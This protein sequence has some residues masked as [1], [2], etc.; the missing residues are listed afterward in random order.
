MHRPT[1]KSAVK[2]FKIAPTNL[3]T[4]IFYQ[5]PAIGHEQLG[6]NRLQLKKEQPTDER[7]NRRTEE[8]P[9][10]KTVPTNEQI[11]APKAK[12]TSTKEIGRMY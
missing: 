4:A 3:I 7:T 6:T 10:L 11:S 2:D 9:N 12:P 1:Q 5:L 8:P